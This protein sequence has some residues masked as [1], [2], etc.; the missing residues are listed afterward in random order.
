MAFHRFRYSLGSLYHPRMSAPKSAYELAMEKLRKKDAE[1]GTE[2][3]VLTD[4]QRA[5][6]AEAKNV[7]E[8]RVAERRIMHQSAIAGVFDPTER[9]ERET[10]LRRDLERFAS[11]RDAKI[12]K[13][14][15][16]S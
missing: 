8:S 15:S 14:R 10:E 6:I 2:T 1:T 11:D 16:G 7:Y 4:A 3:Q 12:K 9:E 5:E 13:I